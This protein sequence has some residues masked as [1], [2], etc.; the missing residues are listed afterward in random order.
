MAD[1]GIC[2][3]ISALS[4]QISFVLVIR[5]RLT[6][7]HIKGSRIMLEGQQMYTYILNK[8]DDM[9][10]NNHICYQPFIKSVLII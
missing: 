1:L 2:K 9:I 4:L 5:N 7:K 10:V 3:W 6:T 8:N